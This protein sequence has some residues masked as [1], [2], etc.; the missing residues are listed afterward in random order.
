MYLVSTM[1]F[2]PLK[3]WRPDLRSSLQLCKFSTK[4]SGIITYAIWNAI[5]KLVPPWISNQRIL[6]T[7]RP[8]H[9]ALLQCYGKL[10]LRFSCN[11]FNCKHKNIDDYVILMV[12]CCGIRRENCYIVN[13][14]PNSYSSSKYN[15]YSLV[16][17]RRL[18][19][20]N[21]F[22]LISK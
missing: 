13:F 15:W 1:I 5:W 21:E 6:I 3:F 18:L 9:D 19:T 20:R 16:S 22:L 2:Q 10:K 14:N 7:T 12:I 8:D 17:T 4:F 11:S